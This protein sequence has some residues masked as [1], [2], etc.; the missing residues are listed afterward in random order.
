VLKGTNKQLLQ[1]AAL[2]PSP[3]CLWL[4]RQSHVVVAAT[5][6][7]AVVV[8]SMVMPLPTTAA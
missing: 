2:R 3:R 6:A 7:V 1:A 5:E 8:L 4:R